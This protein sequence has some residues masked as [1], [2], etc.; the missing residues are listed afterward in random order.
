MAS[1]Q[2]SNT[3]GAY[4]AETHLSELLEKVEACEE[5]TI[6]KHGARNFRL[7]RAGT[8]VKTA[9]QARPNKEQAEAQL[10]VRVTRRDRNRGNQGKVPV[11]RRI[12]VLPP[13][14]HPQFEAGASLLEGRPA[15][16]IPPCWAARRRC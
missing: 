6:T 7:G 11:P 10:C 15:S 4:E 2:G 3:V 16:R 14:G 12:L 8:G 5:I 1:L 13:V 9:A